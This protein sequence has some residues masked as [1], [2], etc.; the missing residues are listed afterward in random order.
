MKVLSALNDLMRSPKPAALCTVVSSEGSTPRKAGAKML[1]IKNNGQGH[2]IIN[3]IGGGAIEHFITSEALLAIELCEPRFITTSLR[4][5]LAMCCGGAMSVFIEPIK[6]TPQLICFGAGHIAQALCQI[7]KNLDFDIHVLDSRV[8]LLE[9]LAFKNCQSRSNDLSS[10][11][12]KNLPWGKNSYIIVTTHDHQ[13][14]QQIIESVLKYEFKYLALVGSLRKAFMTKKRL[15]AK[16]FN[17]ELRDKLICPAGININAQS[18]EEIAIS[19][20]AQIIQVRHEKIKTMRTDRSSRP[21][22]PHGRAQST[23]A[24]SG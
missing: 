8:D 2:Q 10:F 7:V 20:A 18:P 14:D 9:S 1:V 5:D 12:F 15:L 6:Y 21:E 13:L 24:Y 17:K 4:N 22:Q 19:I 16:D 23:H 11:S 3:T